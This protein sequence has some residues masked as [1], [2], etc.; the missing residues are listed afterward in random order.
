MYTGGRWNLSCCLAHECRFRL[1]M[2]VFFCLQTEH[3]RIFAVLLHQCVVASAFDDTALFQHIDKEIAA[4]TH[5]SD[6][7]P[8]MR[9]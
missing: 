4:T 9:S 2:L 6:G 8:H 1:H 3:F 5:N 7:W